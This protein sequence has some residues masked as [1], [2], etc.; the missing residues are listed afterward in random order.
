MNEIIFQPLFEADKPIGFFASFH[1]FGMNGYIMDFDRCPNYFDWRKTIK[2]DFCKD[3]YD[4]IIDLGNED[5][6]SLSDSD[7][8]IYKLEEEFEYDFSCKLDVAELYIYSHNPKKPGGYV[9]ILTEPDENETVKPKINTSD[10]YPEWVKKAGPVEKFL[11]ANTDEWEQEYR[12][13]ES[14]KKVSERFIW[15]FGDDLVFDPDILWLYFNDEVNWNELYWDLYHAIGRVWKRCNFVEAWRSCECE[16]TEKKLVA[17]HDAQRLLFW[18]LENQY[19]L[20]DLHEMIEAKQIIQK[21][22]LSCDGSK[23]I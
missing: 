21:H 16:E 18:T 19:T 23:L 4:H 6:Y 13:P 3:L 9:R 17:E 8:D 14:L 12:L 20:D 7:H 5:E 10:F 2:E 1:F 22:Y 15:R 11:Y